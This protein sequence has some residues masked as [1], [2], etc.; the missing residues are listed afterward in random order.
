MVAPLVKELDGDWLAS[1][2]RQSA[3]SEIINDPSRGRN[4]GGRGKGGIVAEAGN[5]VPGR[6]SSL[7]TKA[8]RIKLRDMKRIRRGE[9]KRSAVEARMRR[10]AAGR[11]RPKEIT[12]EDRTTDS[13]VVARGPT[14]RKS[15]S[16]SSSGDGS[17][18]TSFRLGRGER[19][20]GGG[21]GGGKKKRGIMTM[22]SERALMR[23]SAILESSITHITS[24]DAAAV[25]HRRLHP[26]SIR[27]D[28]AR[29]M[30][31][32]GLPA[33]PSGKAT[34]RST[35]R[36]DSREMQPRK[37]D[38]NGQGLARPSIYVPFDDPGFGPKVMMEFEEH[39]PG[40]FG[41]AKKRAA[42]RQADKDMLWRKCLRAREEGGGDSGG[43][44]I[45]T[46]IEGRGKAN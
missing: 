12:T 35:I 17:S 38:Y 30:I 11:G 34:R 20:G 32:N 41:K 2:A 13:G 44:C 10:L 22:L 1:L 31:V 25:P 39:V 24:E 46:T 6:S 37:R 43:G 5:D 40:F 18:T 14:A 15:S 3:R 45:K 4:N 42:K 26:S 21:G 27:E 9:R 29:P 19:S 8:E 36:H 23:L 16:S 7:L 33:E 28:D